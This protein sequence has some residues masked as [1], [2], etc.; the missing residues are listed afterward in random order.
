MTKSGSYNFTPQERMR[1]GMRALDALIEEIERR[2]SAR[3][4]VVVSPS[5][6]RVSGQPDELAE[7]L[8]DKCAGVFDALKPH[9]PI[10]CVKTLHEAA[11]AEQVDLFVTFGGGT[12]IDTVKIVIAMMTADTSNPMDVAN[13]VN[14]WALPTVRQIAAPTTLSG[15]EFSD[16]AGLTDPETRIKHGVMGRGIGPACVVLDPELTLHTPLDLWTSTGLRAVDHAVETLCSV[17]PTPYTDALALEALRNLPLALRATHHDPNNKQRRLDAQLAVWM[18]SAGLDRTP[19]GASHGIGHQLGA[20][21]GMP[22]GVC[23]CTML[24][25]VLEWNHAHTESEQV[26]IANALGSDTAANGVRGLVTDLGLPARLSEAGVRRDQLTEVAEKS[27]ANRWVRTNP[28]PI[29]S[30]DD[31]LEILEAAF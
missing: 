18:A 19:Y 28:R 8:G 23:S 10:P 26:R 14:D 22:H 29:G 9:T 3:V 6:R 15:A 5:L 12:P 16:L 1:W 24:P 7:Q 30:A 20:V 13:Q 17:A 4:L 11:M 31:I 2:G 21:A 27:L 25:A